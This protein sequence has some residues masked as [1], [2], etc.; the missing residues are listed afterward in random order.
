MTLTV[1]LAREFASC[2]IHKGVN[3]RL[4]SRPQVVGWGFE[5]LSC[6]AWIARRRRGTAS[7]S[8]SY[9]SVASEAGDATHF[10][11]INN[12]KG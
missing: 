11:K 4:P 7:I 8:L 1:L 9:S 5:S 6:L 10:E 2:A 3:R 12:V